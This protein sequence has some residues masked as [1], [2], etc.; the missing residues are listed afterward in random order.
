MRWTAAGGRGSGAA[1]AKRKTRTPH[2]DVGN[3]S[4][5]NGKVEK[6]SRQEDA[7]QA[8]SKRNSIATLPGFSL[9]GKQQTALFM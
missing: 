5:K 6:T 2:N 3:N 8:R 9:A 7:R 4:K 1:G